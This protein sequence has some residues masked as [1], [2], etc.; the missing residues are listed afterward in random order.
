[1]KVMFHQ[2]WLDYTVRTDAIRAHMSRFVKACQRGMVV[3]SS[4]SRLFVLL[5]FRMV[6]VVGWSVVHG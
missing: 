1:M 3:S 5:L 6:R 4:S 2:I